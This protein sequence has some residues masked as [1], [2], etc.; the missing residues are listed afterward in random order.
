MAFAHRA[1]AVVCFILVVAARVDARSLRRPSPIGARRTTLLDDE[2]HVDSFDVDSKSEAVATRSILRD[3]SSGEWS[4]W[5][6]RS[7]DELA[8]TL[9]DLHA[10]PCAGISKLTSIGTSAGGVAMRAM[11]ISTSPGLEQAKPGIMLVGNMHGDEPVGR[12]LI[13][14]FARLLCIAHGGGTDLGRLGIWTRLPKNS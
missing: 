9:D 11:E 5:R 1:W 3:A 7:N 4:K 6:Y 14:R 13:V 10:G 8:A 2:F 12:E